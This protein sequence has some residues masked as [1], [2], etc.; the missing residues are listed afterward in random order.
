MAAVN[1]KWASAVQELVVNYLRHAAAVEIAERDLESTGEADEAWQVYAVVRDTKENYARAAGMSSKWVSIFKE[2]YVNDL[3]YDAAPVE[4][5]ERD[6]VSK[7]DAAE[8]W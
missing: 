8:A 4:I 5:V 2:F 1:L 6:S 3:R 7:G